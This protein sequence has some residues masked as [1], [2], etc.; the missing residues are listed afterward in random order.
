MVWVKCATSAKCK[1]I[2]I[3]VSVVMD[4][5]EGC[6]RAVLVLISKR[7]SEKQRLWKCFD[8]GMVEKE[9]GFDHGMVGRERKEFGRGTTGRKEQMGDLVLMFSKTFQKVSKMFS[10]VFNK[11]K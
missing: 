3:A 9:K 6:C 7:I 5:W 10:Q 1:S 4:G 11:D 8:H 2:R